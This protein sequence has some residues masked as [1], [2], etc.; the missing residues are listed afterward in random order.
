M[1]ILEKGVQIRLT[2]L[3]AIKRVFYFCSSCKIYTCPSHLNKNGNHKLFILKKKIGFV[4]LETLLTQQVILF[5]DFRF[6]FF[7]SNMNGPILVGVFEVLNENCKQEKI[8]IKKAQNGGSCLV[9]NF[10]RIQKL[11]LFF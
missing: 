4:I 3:I 9:T 11:S 8:E 2:V 1:K 7:S 5:F 10:Q 6:N